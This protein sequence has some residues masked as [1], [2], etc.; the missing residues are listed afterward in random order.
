MKVIDLHHK[1]KSLIEACLKNNRNAQFQLYKQFSA[2]MLSVCRMY[3]KDL[4]Y[5]EDVMSKGFLKAFTQLHRFQF[6]GSFE[7]WLRK[8]MTRESI[9]F[10]RRQKKVEFPIDDFR[11]HEKED[12]TEE[13]L[14]SVRIEEAQYLID[15]LPEGYKMVFVMYEIEGYRHKEIAELLSIK[16]STSKS[17]LFKA[18]KYIAE[19]INS[20]KTANG[21][22]K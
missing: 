15:Q 5:A 16:E 17:Q 22:S 9:D 2:E 3:T 21:K 10:L 8:I 7:G 19:A 18:R 11:I 20:K 6:Q 1:H 4:H 13:V 14:D 12:E